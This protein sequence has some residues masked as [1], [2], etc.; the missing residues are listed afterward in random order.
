MYVVLFNWLGLPNKS[1]ILQR[2]LVMIKAAEKV[3][4][5]KTKD[6]PIFGHLILVM[7]DVKQKAAEI[8]A[9]V[10]D[11]EDGGL[12]HEDAEGV[13]ERNLIRKRL[14]DG[15][16]PLSEVSPGFTT[17]LD[18][19]RDT[20]AEHLTTPH[21]FAGQPITGGERLHDIVGGLCEAVNST[22]DICFPRP[23][24][25][26]SATCYGA[27]RSRGNETPGIEVT[28]VAEHIFVSLVACDGTRL[29][30]KR[31]VVLIVP[32]HFP[33][34][35]GRAL[36]AGVLVFSTRAV[37]R[38]INDAREKAF[39]QFCL[40]AVLRAISSRITKG[41]QEELVEQMSPKAAVVAGSQ[42][43]K[44]RARCKRGYH[45]P[46]P[47]FP[48]RRWVGTRP[49]NR[50]PFQI[51]G[52]GKSTGIDEHELDM[53]WNQLVGSTFQALHKDFKKMTLVN[54]VVNEALLHELGWNLSRKYAH[55]GAGTQP[56][57]AC[58]R[59]GPQGQGSR[60]EI[61]AKELADRN[62]S[63]QRQTVE[64]I[65]QRDDAR[66][67]QPQRQEQDDPN[68]A[69]EN[70]RGVLLLQQ[71]MGGGGVFFN[72]WALLVTS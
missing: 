43:T 54:R 61:S 48:G 72:P 18:E 39:E 50:M 55:A 26:E 17:L 57:G 41:V 21:M 69:Y 56:H 68:I 34:D 20:T 42:D 25:R 58:T 35:S 36:C 46:K 16:V 14:G 62:A 38:T 49:S 5:R 13:T 53:K 7:R 63:L 67:R 10:I 51:N 27:K 65:Q 23:V 32:A 19:L 37:T 40:S 24:E 47:T 2:L 59:A 6:E 66:G 22:G 71:L 3:S 31:V 8:E 9:L 29:L 12:T 15:A 52:N 4:R 45:Q 44:R 11:D 60:R 30:W 1:T 64:A 33:L 70:A 28:G